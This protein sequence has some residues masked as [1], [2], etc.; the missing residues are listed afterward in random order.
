MYKYF[1]ISEF[2]SPD[3]PGSGKMMEPSVIEKL[4]IARDIYGHPI[5]I[6]SGFR[7]IARHKYLTEKGYPTSANSSHLLGWA[8]DLH[9]D[10]SAR[11]YLLIEALLDAGFNRIGI[12]KSYLHVDL[13]PEKPSNQIWVY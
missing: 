3:E 2:D 5:I 12:A 4:D 6:N 9:V 8:A 7:T 13:D 11:R 1:K 10:N